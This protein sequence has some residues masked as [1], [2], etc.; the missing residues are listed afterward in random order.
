MLRVG[1][2]IVTH[3]KGLV[4]WLIPGYW[5]HCAMYIGNDQIV[6][7]VYPNVE[8]TFLADLLSSN[9]AFAVLRPVFSTPMRSNI[10]AAIIGTYVG[11]PYDL[12]FGP[13]KDAFYCSEAVW[14]AYQTAV[15]SWDFEARK[16]LGVDTVTP[17]DLYDARKHFGL[18]YELRVG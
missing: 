8:A 12:G 4:A 17:Q 3:K 11:K 5:S 14:H 18:V 15:P 7:A 16:R 9:D 1:D 2:V 10:A 6:H 13:G